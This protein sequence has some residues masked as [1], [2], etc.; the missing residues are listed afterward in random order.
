M[1]DA[2]LSLAGLAGVGVGRW[3]AMDRLVG[4]SHIFYIVRFWDSTLCL[5]AISWS[6]GEMDCLHLKDYIRL[7]SPKKPLLG[8]DY[9]STREK[10]SPPQ[11]PIPFSSHPSFT[12]YPGIPPQNTPPIP[13]SIPLPTRL[14]LVSACSFASPNIH[15][16]TRSSHGI[17][18][19]VSFSTVWFRKQ[20]K[21]TCA[22]ARLEKEEGFGKGGIVRLRNFTGGGVFRFLGSPNWESRVDGWMDLRGFV[23]KGVLGLGLR[24]D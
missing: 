1:H 3:D 18:Q 20:E 9:R 17:A 10:P 13:L 7:L 11:T 14:L 23:L 5:F 24:K 15:P 21:L 6:I 19:R 4:F 2:I 16:T 22:R 8:F 12:S